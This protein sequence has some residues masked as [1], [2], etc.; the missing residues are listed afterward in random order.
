MSA[1]VAILGA[2][3]A[4]AAGA[5]ACA[6]AA[7]VAAAEESGPVLVMVARGFPLVQLS[8]SHAHQNSGDCRKAGVVFRMPGSYPIAGALAGSERCSLWRWS[9]ASRAW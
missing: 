7:C 8:C 2:A 4:V 5:A 1:G 3:G 6:D 9:N